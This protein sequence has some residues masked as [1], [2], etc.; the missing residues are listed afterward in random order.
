MTRPDTSVTVVEV[1]T[2]VA[3]TTVVFSDIDGTLIDAAYSYA[4]SQPAVAALLAHGIPLVLCSSKTRA[5]QQ[6]LRA[7]LGIPD[8]FIVENGSA[9][10]IPAGYF[11][12]PLPSSRRVDGWQVLEL[13]VGAASIRAA[14]AR[15]RRQTGL[16]IQGYAGLS[17]AQVA[18]VTGLDLPAAAR[19][20]QREYS[21]TIVTPLSA[22][23][24]ARL[25]RELAAQGLNIVSGGKFYTVTGAASD[26]GVAVARL[27]ALF[28]Q[29]WGE[30]ITI[31]LG[32]S[33]NDAPLLAAVDR[34]YLVQKPGGV[35]QEMPDVPARRV[36]ARRVPA[37]GPL[38]WRQAV[39]AEL[40]L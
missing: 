3:S 33:A 28:R 2:V 21:E 31:G 25:Q 27:T 29:Q 10:F 23:D 38:G 4:Q 11:P 1:T 37:V 26:K 30:A 35:W 14:L 40:G 19:A 8:P 5:E 36:P 18:Q 39:M 34:P 9:I 13:G 32:D 17:A 12:F 20:Q 6:A 16:E 7:A 15:L 22:A 24:L